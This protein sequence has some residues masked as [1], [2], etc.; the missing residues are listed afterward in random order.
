M[1]KTISLVVLISLFNAKS[2]SQE[3]VKPQKNTTK[4]IGKDYHNIEDSTLAKTINGFDVKKSK[5]DNMVYLNVNENNPSLNKMPIAVNN[6]PVEPMPVARPTKR[7]EYFKKDTSL[8]VNI[9]IDS[10]GRR[11]RN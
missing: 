6:L 10:L 7:N 1:K 11:K 9:T 4:A 2:F 5:I 8:S 3:V